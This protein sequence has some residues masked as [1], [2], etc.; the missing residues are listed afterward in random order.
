MGANEL[1]KAYYERAGSYSSMAVPEGVHHF[2][3]ELHAPVRR[4]SLVH[5]GR[6]NGPPSRFYPGYLPDER[7]VAEVPTA[8]G[9]THPASSCAGWSNPRQR[10]PSSSAASIWPPTAIW[11]TTRCAASRPC[12]VRSSPS[13]R[14]RPPGTWRRTSMSSPSRTCGSSTSSGSTAVCRPPQAT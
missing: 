2:V 14:R 5:L 10:P 6:P 8:P 13:W 4:P 1:T 7:A 3:Q 9:G 11:N 12:R